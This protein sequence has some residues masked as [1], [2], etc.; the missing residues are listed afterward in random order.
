MGLREHRSRVEVLQK[1][2]RAA[3]HV[4]EGPIEFGEAVVDRLGQK[5][6]V[7]GDPDAIGLLAGEFVAGDV[8]VQQDRIVLDERAGAAT[9]ADGADVTMC[10][11][12]LLDDQLEGLL[13]D[14]QPEV[15]HFRTP[16]LRRERVER[17]A[18]PVEVVVLE[19]VEHAI[20]DV[21]GLGQ[22]PR[23]QVR[24]VGVPQ[25]G[26]E[27]VVLPAQ[28]DLQARQSVCRILEAGVDDML[29]AEFDVDVLVSQLVGERKHVGVQRQVVWQTDAVILAHLRAP[30]VAGLA[31]EELRLQ[32]LVELG[33]GLGRT[34][35]QAQQA[36]FH[37]LGQTVETDIGVRPAPGVGGASDFAHE[38]NLR[39]DVIHRCGGGI[40]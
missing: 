32:Q 7:L 17:D 21:T 16:L 3:Y 1:R 39:L 13:V 36:T 24:H 34:G 31:T 18:A 14:G 9:L 4:R 8:A 10:L 2:E 23:R 26:G 28:I 12:L 22:A 6:I 30:Q 15:G 27:L 29:D 33:A 11:R 5:T 40:S 35:Q 37:V 19:E 20:E 38:W 25:A